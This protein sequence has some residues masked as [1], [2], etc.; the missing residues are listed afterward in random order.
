MTEKSR[1][2]N[3]SDIG[4]IRIFWA[5]AS[6]GMGLLFAFLFFDSCGLMDR[7]K[8][9]SLS[10]HSGKDNLFQQYVTACEEELRSDGHPVVIPPMDCTSEHL[11]AIDIRPVFPSRPS[12]EPGRHG[13][14]GRCDAPSGL[15]G[16]YPF[17]QGHPDNPCMQGSLIGR[18]DR[19]DLTWVTVC[20]KYRHYEDPFLFDDVNMIGYNRKTGKTCFFNSK[21][22]GETAA[23]PLRFTAAVSVKSAQADLF[24]MTPAQIQASVPCAD[25]HAANPFLRTPHMRSAVQLPE[26][27]RSS[28]YEI[29]WPQY[30]TPDG[31]AVANLR[32]DP[33]DVPEIRGCVGCHAVGG[34]KYCA[35]FSQLAWGL[36]DSK[37]V[38]AQFAGDEAASAPGSLWHASVLPNLGKVTGNE[39]LQ[40][41]PMVAA[42]LQIA[43]R[44][45]QSKNG[46]EQPGNSNEKTQR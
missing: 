42:A 12:E 38:Y 35:I 17:E 26:M 15:L 23:E 25:C 4:R 6:A 16:A 34:G 44:C 31:S 43:E 28:P 11:S 18:Q 8:T 10:G 3:R 45:Q 30:F 32:L 7:S 46:R 21:V 24:F 19:G 41:V 29:V 22:T 9:E 40:R 13:S 20:R 39:S 37:L 5:R 14:Q 2:K 27:N 33:R 1:N 36:Q